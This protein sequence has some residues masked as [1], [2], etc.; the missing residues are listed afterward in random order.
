MPLRVMNSFPSRVKSAQTVPKALPPSRSG[1]ASSSDTAAHQPGSPASLRSN[2]SSEDG[3]LLTQHS[4][5]GSKEDTLPRY[6]DDKNI[7]TRYLEKEKQR[8]SHEF[9]PYE[10]VNVQQNLHQASSSSS[11]RLVSRTGQQLAGAI[12]PDNAPHSMEIDSIP[13]AGVRIRHG[14]LTG[15][16]AW[17]L[18]VRV[19]EGQTCNWWETKALKRRRRISLA[20][21]ALLPPPPHK[22]VH[23]HSYSEW[24]APNGNQLKDIL[25]DSSASLSSS[26]LPLP[27]FPILP[28][29]KSHDS[30]P[31]PPPKTTS[32]VANFILDTSLPHS[33]ISRETLLTLGYPISQLP[34]S[35]DPNQTYDESDDPPTVTLSIQGISTRL[36]IANPGESSRLGVQFLQDAGVS[37]FF[38]KD[39]D[40]V[41]PVLYQESVRTM[42]DIPT[43]LPNGARGNRLSLQQRVRNLF[44]M[45]T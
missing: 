28:R 37:V 32:L 16:L 12:G 1:S 4:A 2:T 5:F 9:D 20:P 18:V 42:Q 41:G 14:P 11:R 40:G 22:P 6:S 8:I 27:K 13:C 15:L 34:P 23:S 7:Y 30:A 44:G 43:T 45:T 21:A 29:H 3:T 10:A 36:Q 25:R 19:P 35:L 17:R 39:G 33:L 26:S 38:P 31:T 24:N